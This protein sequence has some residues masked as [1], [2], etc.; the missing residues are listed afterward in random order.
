MRI[1]AKRNYENEPN[2]KSGAE[3]I[4]TELKKITRH[5]KH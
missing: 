3:N 2:R 5:F 1:S 4:I